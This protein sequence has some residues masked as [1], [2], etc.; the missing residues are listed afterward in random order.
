MPKTAL[1]PRRVKRAPASQEP[2]IVTQPYLKAAQVLLI[3]AIT[4][5]VCIELYSP[6]LHGLLFFDDFGLPLAQPEASH[7]PLAIWLSGVRPVLMLSYLLNSWMGGRETFAYHFTNLLIHT[8]NTGLVFAIALR[9]LLL[10]GCAFRNR[11]ILASLAGAIFLIHPLQT[12]SVSY[13]AGRSESLG[14]FFVLAAWTV[15]LYRKQNE[16]TWPVSIAVLALS[17]LAAGSKENMI[18]VAGLLLLTDFFWNHPFSLRGIGGNWRLYVPLGVGSAALLAWVIRILAESHSAG[19]GATNFTPANYFLTQS[20]VLW[21]YVRLFLFPTNQSID[22]D[23]STSHTVFEH[24][25]ILAILAWSA[26]I[27]LAIRER[28]RHPLACFGLFVFLIALAPT[29]SVVPIADAMVERRMYLPLFGLALIV[30]DLLKRAKLTWLV[31]SALSCVLLFYGVDTYRRNQLWAKPFAFW[32]EAVEQTPL[33]GRT[34]VQLA[35]AAN[36]EGQCRQVQPY[37]DRVQSQMQH[38]EWFLHA[39]AVL[40]ECTG[41]LNAAM[42]SLQKA[43][44]IKPDASMFELQGLLYGEMGKMAESKVALDK[45][46]ALAPKSLNP[47]QPFESRGYWYEVTRHYP[48]AIH[49]YKAALALNKSNYQARSR[50]SALTGSEHKTRFR[51]ETASP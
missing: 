49:D 38:D 18:A 16:I 25:A 7:L 13:I 36:R 37:F 3:A 5:L 27:W 23:F 24:G 28:N 47:D 39:R 35:G 11:V 30:C 34:Y 51:R 50:L 1:K 2:L 33:K 44:A 32:L 41:N 4:L 6:S 46:I 9:L 10:A 42:D 26:L 29:S 31:L 12:E 15:F 19:F 8:A 17:A 21:E 20:R 22:H 45:A 43:V 40:Y 48:E 14:S